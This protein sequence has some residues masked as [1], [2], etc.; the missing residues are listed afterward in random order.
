MMAS[1]ELICSRAH[2][3]LVAQRAMSLI[4]VTCLA[5]GLMHLGN[6]R[7]GKTAGEDGE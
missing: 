3:E 2:R 6:P 7:T 5:C 1:R 4:G